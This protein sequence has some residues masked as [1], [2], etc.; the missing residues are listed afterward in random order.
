MPRTARDFANYLKSRGMSAG[1][2]VAGL[3]PRIPD[4]FTVILGAWRIGALYQPLFTRL[5]ACSGRESRHRGRREQGE[6]GSSPTTAN[7]PKL[8]DAPDCRPRCRR[9]RLLRDACRA[10]NRLRAGHDEGVRSVR[11]AV[12]LGTT[13]KPKGRALSARRCCCRSPPT[14][15]TLIDLQPHDC[16]WNVADPGWAYGMLYAVIGPLLLG[17]ATTFYVGGFTVESTLHIR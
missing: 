15:S 2:V 11:R 5:R 7:L 4:L 13:G 9:R 6:A 16:Y 12:H 14:C 3:L 17:H 1:D 8:K 10:I